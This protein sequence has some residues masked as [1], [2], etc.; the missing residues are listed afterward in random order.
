VRE[1][2]GREAIALIP[3][4]KREEAM[5][6]RRIGQEELF[7]A[8]DRVSPLDDLLALIDWSEVAVRLDVVHAAPKGEASWPP[9]AMFRALLLWSGTTCRT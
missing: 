2:D 9:L 1:G 5:P 6:R 7:A 8:G 4:R 3:L